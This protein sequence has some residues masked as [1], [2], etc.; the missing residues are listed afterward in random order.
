MIIIFYEK[1]S[2]LNL[3]NK[4]INELKINNNLNKK[5]KNNNIFNKVINYQKKENIVIILK[6]QVKENPQNL[7]QK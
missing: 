5:N 3:N 4:K 7:F 2:N 1:F 6:V